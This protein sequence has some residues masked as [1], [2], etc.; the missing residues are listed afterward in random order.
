[1]KGN[2]GRGRRTRRLGDCCVCVSHSARPAAGAAC[3]RGPCSAWQGAGRPWAASC[4]RS[5]QPPWP[6]TLTS[7][8][9][10]RRKVSAWSPPLTL[11]FL[12]GRSSFWVCSL[13]APRR[14]GALWLEGP[15]FLALCL[16]RIFS[17]FISPSFSH[18]MAH[19][20]DPL[21]LTPPQK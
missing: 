8:P 16:L 3:R 11:A 13:E 21:F 17:H 20:A 14:W 19:G 1:M 18:E 4:T 5:P 15:R 9:L 12:V 2:L 10:Q 6:A 7:A